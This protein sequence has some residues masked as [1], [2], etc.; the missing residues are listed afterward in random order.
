MNSLDDFNKLDK[1]NCLFY[2]YNSLPTNK[3]ILFKKQVI[4]ECGWT[5]YQW[6]N[7][8]YKKNH[9]TKS[10]LYFIER[11]YGEIIEMKVKVNL[12]ALCKIAK[13][14]QSGTFRQNLES[15]VIEQS[16]KEL[17]GKY[18]YNFMKGGLISV[19]QATT[20][21]GC[22]EKTA[23]YKLR[24]IAEKYGLT[25]YFKG[26]KIPDIRNITYEMFCEYQH[27]NPDF[28]DKV[29]TSPKPVL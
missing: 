4:S 17:Y 15:T 10:E 24:L 21:Y 14:E 8:Y 18:W 20:F 28:L 19:K 3:R 22:C 29:L 7:R 1:D 23:R 2:F 25:K 27:T 5:T 12:M 26:H 13:V 16:V 9:T 6:D 11:I